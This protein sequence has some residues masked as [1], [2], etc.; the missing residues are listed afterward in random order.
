MRKGIITAVLVLVAAIAYYVSPYSVT[1][2]QRAHITLENA[3]KDPYVGVS[4]LALAVVSAAR[5]DGFEVE[6]MDKVT[7]NVQHLRM[8]CGKPQPDDEYVVS[9]AEQV[10]FWVN[11]A[12]SNYTAHYINQGKLP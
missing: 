12:A 8:E 9:L 11:L 3:C 1:V 5:R 10:R 7:T 6:Y 4:D 2:S